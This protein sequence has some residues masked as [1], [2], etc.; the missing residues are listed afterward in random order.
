M[1]KRQ[2]FPSLSPLVFEALKAGIQINFPPP[3]FDP[4]KASPEELETF[5]LPPIPDP[6]AA[7]QA[8]ANWI[9]AM[10]PP[11][12]FP[13]NRVVEELFAATLLRSRYRQRGSGDFSE[14]SSQNWSGGY[15]VPRDFSK[16]TLVQGR[17]RVPDPKPSFAGNGE[18]ASS[19]W[20]GLD[21]HAPTSRSMPQVGTGQYVS[22]AGG[23]PSLDLFAWW[24]WWERD[25]PRGQ[26]IRYKGFPILAGQTVYT[27][28]QALS[29]TKVSVFVKN[30]TTGLAFPHWYVVQSP[31]LVG[32][33]PLPPHVEGRTAEWIV[34]RPTNP[35]TGRYFDLANYGTA[36]FIDCHGA[37][38]SGDL[39]LQ[40]ARLI[41]MNEW[42]VGSATP[43][44]VASIPERLSVSSLRTR[45]R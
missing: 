3:G 36:T 19:V 26:Q 22:V 18:F 41:R 8:H 45:Y 4:L 15:I 13:E 23:P 20:V 39:R 37:C 11:L 24:Q 2:E 34:E 31:P 38:V 10:S 1:P 28:I 35:R 14:E 40:R 33:N 43:G 9:K 7:P 25:D 6:R 12:S 21:G 16:M 42:D 27:Q 5:F 44:K 29:R 30:E 32:T 17:W